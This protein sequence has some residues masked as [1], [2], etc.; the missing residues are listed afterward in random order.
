MRFWFL[1]VLCSAGGPSLHGLQSGD[2]ELA[3]AMQ[4][5]VDELAS[6]PSRDSVLLFYQLAPE[7]VNASD[8]EVW[9]DEG[10]CF[11]SSTGR[12]G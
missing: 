7:T 8:F 9:L 1:M 11:R 6:R 2:R 10:P 4:A 5:L 12:C 3:V